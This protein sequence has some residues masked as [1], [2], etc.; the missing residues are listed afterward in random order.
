MYQIRSGFELP[1]LDSEREPG[2]MGTEGGGKLTAALP[3]S[4]GRPD[5]IVG[6][7]VMVPEH[8]SQHLSPSAR[9]TSYSESRPGRSAEAVAHGLRL[10]GMSS[11]E[12]RM[13]LAF[14]SGPRGA[15]EAAEIAG[16]HRA[17]AYRVLLRLLD[18]GLVTSIGQTPRRFQA[19]DPSTLFRRL[20]LF[21]RD[22]T[23]LPGCFAEAFAARGEVRLG[24]LGPLPVLDAPPRILAP[25]GRSTHP[26]IVE[27]SQ[28]KRAVAAVV[29]PL[30]TPVAYRTALVRALGHLARSGIHLRLIT[31]ATPADYRFCRAVVREAGGAGA[32]IQIRHYSPVVS[33]L[34]SIDRQTIV[35]IPSLGA[36]NRSP[37][38]GLAICDRA[39]VQILV[40]RFESLWT[41]AA[42]A[43]LDAASGPEPARSLTRNEGR[44]AAS[45]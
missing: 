15:R 13:Y 26:A 1:C 14:L 5:G 38:V 36:S 4:G 17:T 18:R 24:N 25:E 9:P 32:P 44:M 41:E 42:S 10:L 45:S 37:P 34:Y 16:L 20:E 39:R 27:L 30:S 43:A 29:R 19:M 12:A 35:R 28:A 3:R 6:R 31:D 23:E 21:Y 22:E 2:R 40:N 33:Q 11:R 7:G 8:G